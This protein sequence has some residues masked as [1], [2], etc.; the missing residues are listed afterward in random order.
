MCQ[1]L[2]QEQKGLCPPPALHLPKAFHCS[3]DY[4]PSP[5][6][7]L[8]RCDRLPDCFCSLISV[9][10][11]AEA[12]EVFFLLP[13]KPDYSWS[14]LLCPHNS[15]ITSNFTFSER[16]YLTRDSFPS[17]LFVASLALQTVSSIRAGTFFLVQ[18]YKL[19]SIWHL[20]LN[21]YLQNEGFKD[22][23][24]LCPQGVS[25]LFPTVM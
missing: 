6:S 17:R 1:V 20:V 25:F 4:N 18:N 8:T 5:Q 21:K 14:L 2:C 3:L 19:S 11:Y 23:N 13:D 15:S 12:L 10:Y 22:R 7:W 24:G 16:L 9:L